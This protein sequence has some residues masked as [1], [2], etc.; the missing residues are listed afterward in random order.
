MSANRTNGL[1]PAVF[2]PGFSEQGA[3]EDGFKGKK[4]HFRAIQ[5]E[6]SRVMYFFWEQICLL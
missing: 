1:M 2:S 6:P 4:T 3:Q 5:K